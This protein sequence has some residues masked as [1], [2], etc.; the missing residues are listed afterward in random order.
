MVTALFAETPIVRE[1]VHAVSINKRGEF[2]HQGL[3]IKYH[4][5]TGDQFANESATSDRIHQLRNSYSMW[6]ANEVKNQELI[7]RENDDNSSSFHVL[8]GV[9]GEDG[10]FWLCFSGDTIDVAKPESEQPIEIRH[11]QMFDGNPLSEVFRNATF[12][13][14]LAPPRLCLTRLSSNE[15]ARTGHSDFHSSSQQ[16]SAALA[17]AF[18]L[19]T[20]NFPGPYILQAS[21]LLT[22]IFPGLGFPSAQAYLGV[23]EDVELRVNDPNEQIDAE[24][25]EL[26]FNWPGYWFA[27]EELANQIWLLH[28]QGLITDADVDLMY[29][30]YK[31]DSEHSLQSASVTSQQKLEVLLKQRNR[32]YFLYLFQE[33]VEIF[34]ILYTK[35]P[36]QPQLCIYQRDQLRYEVRQ[37][38]GDNFF[39]HPEDHLRQEIVNGSN[40]VTLVR[41][42]DLKGDINPDFDLL[43]DQLDEWEKTQAM[44]QLA[45]VCQEIVDLKDGLLDVINIPPN[46][47]ESSQKLAN[48]LFENKSCSLLIDR[49]TGRKTLILDQALFDFVYWSRTNIDIDRTNKEILDHTAV[50]V[51]GA[52]TGAAIAENFGWYCRKVC[53][54][55]FDAVSLSNLS[56]LGDSFSVF[57]IGRSK[58]ETVVQSLTLRDPYANHECYPKSLDELA[59]RSLIERL[60]LQG[61]VNIVLVDAM[62]DL[63]M[64]V[65]IRKVAKDCGLSVWMNTNT[66]FS[67]KVQREDPED[68]YF[69]MFN[70]EEINAK[71]SHLGEVAQVYIT[72]NPDATPDQIK[73]HMMISGG[74]KLIIEMVG[75]EYLPLT[76]LANFILMAKGLTK[77]INQNGVSSEAGAAA[78]VVNAFDF[79]FGNNPAK[80]VEMA[81][82]RNVDPMDAHLLHL[83][84]TQYAKVFSEYDDGGEGTTAKSIINKALIDIFGINTL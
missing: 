84:R 1:Y 65:T 56:R 36:L 60:K 68:L 47:F 43:W 75:V 61:Y 40:F 8:V 52:S 81:R 80:I 51:F 33:K 35:V 30:K 5:L 18:G 42:K 83:L 58:A 11:W 69:L 19:M 21:P 77:H 7:R 22:K 38:L 6:G 29:E 16:K 49:N 73:Q 37:I 70:L 57:D 26:A 20:D 25:R 17:T 32:K 9:E 76:Q 34:D 74:V 67:P 2:I 39:D 14:T 78:L 63:P 82:A 4:I 28:E 15:I 59:L 54:A 46:F 27:V 53:V 48:Y 44:S 55:D 45:I 66:G 71:L 3:R 24:I 64:K 31:Q 72:Q 62:D 12:N 10:T 23:D 79:L 13:G 50:I 41:G